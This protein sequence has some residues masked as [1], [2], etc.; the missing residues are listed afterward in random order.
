MF[1]KKDF[2]LFMRFRKRLSIK[3]TVYLCIAIPFA[4]AATLFIDHNYESEKHRA[5]E[6]AKIT[7][8][9]LFALN[10]AVL[11]QFMY[12]IR[13]KMMKVLQ[14]IPSQNF[15]KILTSSI[16][17]I[18]I[19]NNNYNKSGVGHYRYKLCTIN[20]RHPSDEADSF[21]ADIIRSFNNDRKIKDFQ[22]IRSIDGKPYYIILR[23]FL[24]VETSCLTCHS[25]PEAAPVELVASYGRERGFNW[26]VDHIISAASIQVPLAA[27]LAAA[28]A[29]AKI[30]SLYFFGFLCLFLALTGLLLNLLVLNPLQRAK[31]IAKRI[32]KNPTKHLGER[33]TPP[34]GRELAEFAQAFND[35]SMALSDERA[36]LDARVSER[37]RE[38]AEANSKLQILSEVDG[39]TGLANRRKFDRVYRAAWRHACDNALPIAVILLDVDWFKDFNDTYGHQAGD[40]CLRDVAQTLEQAT[41]RNHELVARYGGEEFVVVL[42]GLEGADAL[43]VA[44]RIGQAVENAGIRH[45]KGVLGTVVTLSA[46]VAF[47]RPVRG[48]S[49]E[50][51][52][53]LAD[54]ALYKAKEKGRNQAVLS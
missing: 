54:T 29:T 24:P 36:Q 49:P 9:S 14:E 39:L 47:C 32:A 8:E 17:N 1:D 5:I 48:Q 11:D 12:S 43:A 13:P 3:T 20:S 50:S 34:R 2:D 22:G 38:L 19:I 31:D 46:G 42:P 15:D 28:H 26:P 4:V 10:Q 23:P 52:L 27:S 16:Y 44:Q 18:R 37:T 40:D 51:L 30:S 25:T 41:R 53:K 35:M 21:E 6:E 45:D 33:I 7:A